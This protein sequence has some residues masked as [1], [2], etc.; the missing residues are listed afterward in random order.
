MVGMICVTLLHYKTSGAGGTCTRT[1]EN[2]YR[3]VFF[4]SFLCCCCCCCL[5]LLS[6]LGYTQYIPYSHKLLTTNNYVNCLSNFVFARSI[7]LFHPPISILEKILMRIRSISLIFVYP[8][9]CKEGK[10][11]CLY[12]ASADSNGY[13]HMQTPLKLCSHAAAMKIVA[14]SIVIC[15]VD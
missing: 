5:F 15:V 9:L 2:W 10:K 6:F 8:V 1:T 3:F 4:S 12:S 14:S 11:V 7:C 13:M